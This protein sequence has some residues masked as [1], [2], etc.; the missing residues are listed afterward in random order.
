MFD[1][2][3][4]KVY[5]VGLGGLREHLKVGAE[6]IRARGV[7]GLYAGFLFKALHL[8]GSGALMAGLIPVFANFTGIPYAGV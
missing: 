1:D 7:L 6:T 4:R 2:P 3:A 8:G 5:G